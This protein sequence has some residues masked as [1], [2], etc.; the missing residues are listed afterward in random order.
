MDVVVVL[1]DVVEAEDARA[2]GE[3]VENLRLRVEAAAVGVVGERVLVDRFAGEGIGGGGGE[4]AVNDAESAAAELFAELVVL[5][6][7]LAH[8]IL[9]S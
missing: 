3:E 1:V 5:F 4:T 6:E 9:G 8:D 7:A 2:R